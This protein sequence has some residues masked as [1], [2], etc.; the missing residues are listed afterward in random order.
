MQVLEISVS[1]GRALSLPLAVC[2]SITDGASD[3]N[4]E[5]CTVVARG[6]NTAS[7][8]NG[9]WTLNFA[10]AVDPSCTLDAVSVGHCSVCTAAAVT[11]GMCPAGTHTFITDVVAPDRLSPDTRLAV[12]VHVGPS[13]FSAQVMIQLEVLSDA[14]ALPGASAEAAARLQSMLVAT[15]VSHWFTAP[16][17]WLHYKRWC[18][19]ALNVGVCDWV[20]C[21][22]SVATAASP[23]G[24]CARQF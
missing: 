23:L 5:V 9:N 7:A 22:P 8:L 19:R 17:L 14:Q 12:R 1:V 16:D 15:Q 3:F 4:P 18:I 21:G 2:L 11:S 6:H 13:L 10:V 20:C 24:M